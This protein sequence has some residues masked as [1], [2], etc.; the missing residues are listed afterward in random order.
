MST[1][2]DSSVDSP[3]AEPSSATTGTTY[4]PARNRDALDE[5]SVPPNADDE[6]APSGPQR[7]VPGQT[8]RRF[9]SSRARIQV[10]DGEP[11]AERRRYGAEGSRRRH[12]QYGQ[13]PHHDFPSWRVG[14][15]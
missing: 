12:E 6:R 8:A 5:A 15:R 14:T 4:A 2:V 3:L 1:R 9:D 10:A 7:G 11:V 13:R